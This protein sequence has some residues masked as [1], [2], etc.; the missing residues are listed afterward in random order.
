MKTINEKRQ[1]QFEFIGIKKTADI[2]LLYIISNGEISNKYLI[3]D[4]RLVE[5]PKTS[6]IINLRSVFFYH[7]INGKFL[8]EDKSYVSPYIKVN[9]KLKYNNFKE[10]KYARNFMKQLN[11]GR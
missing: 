2:F 11:K 1:L 8:N 9:A 3:L 4:L 10:Y 5:Y 7:D 6:G